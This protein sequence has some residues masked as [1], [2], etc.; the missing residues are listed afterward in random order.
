MDTA[1]ASLATDLDRLIRRD[2]ARRG[3]IG[4]DAERGPLCAGHLSAAIDHCVRFG[5]TAWILTGFYIPGGAQ[6]AAET[7]GPPGAAL[8][9]AT[10]HACGFAVRLLT[11][12]PCRSAVTVAA[13]LYGLP[14]DVVV[15]CPQEIDDA[16][17][18]VTA[19]LSDSS[20]SHVIS[21]E[22]V[23]P[24]HSPASW[25]TIRNQ[26]SPA[27]VFQSQVPPAH[28]NRCHNMRGEIIDGWTAPLH[29]VLERV[30]AER[31]GVRTIGIG[32]GGN[33]LG[34][35]AVSWQELRDRLSGP[36]APLVPCRVATD[37]T[38]LAGV[39]NWGAMALA[40]GIAHGRGCLPALQDWNRDG[41]EARLGELVTRGPAVDGVTRLCEPTVDGLPFLTYIQPWEGIRQRLGLD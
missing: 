38:I 1:T 16:E 13:E 37:W 27:T 8:L 20:L 4:S 36:A 2:P 23:G 30:A 25:G 15:C 31:P 32:D 3:L 39:S 19:L 12:E 29:R 17:R 33:E 6:P 18:W 26:S 35:G 41:E 21:V 22:R 24:S 9:A 7:D 34:L 40:A 14:S 5:Q 11:D 10:L 28:W